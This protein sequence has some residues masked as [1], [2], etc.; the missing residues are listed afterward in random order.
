[1]L[2]Y[3][4][5]ISPDWQVAVKLCCLPLFFFLIDFIMQWKHSRRFF[6]GF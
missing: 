1:M 6:S 5:Q 2:F 3:C 4:M